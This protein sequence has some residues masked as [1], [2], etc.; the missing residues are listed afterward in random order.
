[1]SPYENMAVVR[2]DSE[3]FTCRFK[4]ESAVSSSIISSHL[5]V[6]SSRSVEIIWLLWDTSH[7]MFATVLREAD[8]RID[9]DNN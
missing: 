6:N 5:C 8:D 9:K 1:M 2:F 7:K 4:E 3:I